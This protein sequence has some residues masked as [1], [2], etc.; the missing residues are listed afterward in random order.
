MRECQNIDVRD[1]LPDL[2]H[3]RLMAA[4][5]ERV[6][7][8]VA[9]CA[10]CTA[11]LAWLRT[12]RETMN[13]T[14]PRVNVGAIAAGVSSAL[15]QPARLL[16]V[17]GGLSRAAQAARPR[18]TRMSWTSAGRSTALRAAAALAIV[19]AGAAGIIVARHGPQPTR[20][21]PTVATLPTVAPQ[22]AAPMATEPQREAPAPATTPAPAAPAAPSPEPRAT[23]R[24]QPP[25][26]V[27]SAD[28]PTPL[29][30]S[31]SDLS[32]DELKAI[33]RAIDADGGSLP[34]DPAPTPNVVT[35]GGVR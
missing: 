16:V 31:F 15:G 2:L 25:L 3:E 19:A 6:L 24:G 32:D 10:D 29:G 33:I 14:A 4:E 21:A 26:Q 13:A 35:P 23:H 22:P 5:R 9:G 18:A 20:S 17:D 7:L 34:A 8:H 28:V 27:A 30:A 12:A 1:R 11:E